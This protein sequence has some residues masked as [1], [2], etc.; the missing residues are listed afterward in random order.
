MSYQQGYPQQQP[1][2][3][4]QQSGYP[5]APSRGNP[6]TTIIAAVLGLVAAVALVVLNVHLFTDEVSPGMGFGDLRGEFK[7]LVILRFAGALLLLTGLVLMLA[8]KLAGAILLVI[9]ALV[10]AA[11]I[12]V[13]PMLLKDVF[14]ALGL[15]FGDY[16]SDLFKFANV[17]QTFAALALIAAPL[18]LIVAILPPTLRYLRR[19]RGGDDFPQ[20]PQQTYPPQGQQ[21]QGYPQSGQPQQ[22]YPQQPNW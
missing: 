20:Y 10:G 3:G 16:L 2:P 15:G 4:M 7:T 17:Q 12:L 22:G 1:P 9:G 13:V 14:D 21:Q 11:A 19:A 5:A 6:A 18:A 8:R